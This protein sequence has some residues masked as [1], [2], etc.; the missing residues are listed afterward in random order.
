MQM[1][2]TIYLTSLKTK[3][4][5]GYDGL[6]MKHIKQIKSE[7]IKPITLIITQS[8]NTGHFP[9]ELKIAKVIP[10]FKKYDKTNHNNYR[11][12]W[13]YPYYLLSQ[14]YLKKLYINKSMNTLII[15][16]YFLQTNTDSE[17]NIPLNMQYYK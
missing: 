8:L 10:I 15:I 7:L 16:D 11:P 14:R 1:T 2:L 5:C 12:I 4:S 13:Q 3:N 6:S 9:D 17:H